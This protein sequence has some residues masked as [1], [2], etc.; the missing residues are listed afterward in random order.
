MAKFP[1]HKVTRDDK[2]SFFLLF[3]THRYPVKVLVL[4]RLI[5]YL[6]YLSMGFASASLLAFSL[7]SSTME[8]GI[9][10]DRGQSVATPIFRLCWNLASFFL[11]L[12]FHIYILCFTFK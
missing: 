12:D 11:T 8:D 3:I 7:E 9:T 5:E 2:N 4:E 6:V 1:Q 10:A